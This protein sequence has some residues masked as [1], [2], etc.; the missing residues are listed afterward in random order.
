MASEQPKKHSKKPSRKK[1]LVSLSTAVAIIVIA[2]VAFSIATYVKYNVVPSD[3]AF[4]IDGRAYTKE[5]VRKIV[6]YPVVSGEMKQE[7]ATKQAFEYLKRKRTAEKL[8][9]DI[10]Q[11][12][13][14]EHKKELF[15]N[16]PI[17]QRSQWASLVAYD[18]LLEANLEENN[19]NSQQNN[20][21]VGY[22]FMFLF[23]HC[24]ETGP[25]YTPDCAGDKKQIQKDENH[26]KERAEHFRAKLQSRSITPEKV[27]EEM[28][29]DPELGIMRTAGANPSTKFENFESVG[30]EGIDT[31]V[32]VGSGPLQK[33]VE[34]YI[35]SNKVQKGISP[36]MEGKTV[37]DINAPESDPKSWV[38]TYYFFTDVTT[39]S[40]TITK[41]QF[42]EEVKK[43]P[44]R[45]KGLGENVRFDEEAKEGQN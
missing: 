18:D 13:V 33:D 25:D 40:K 11:D 15:S 44:A 30:V 9:I 42:D 20:Q 4:T 8:G 21:I 43:L 24:L 22:V 26:A 27:L 32:T 5:E 7:K 14:T 35:R 29:K 38:P 6:A 39:L 41:Q 37:L 45:F 36:I 19:Q 12:A 23:G 28:Q 10:T 2:L 31:G 1:W 16:N 34:E 17:K 3:A